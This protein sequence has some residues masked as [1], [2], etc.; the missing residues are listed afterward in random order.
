MLTRIAGIKDAVIATLALLRNDLSL[1]TNDWK[2]IEQAIPILKIFNDIT[3][4]IS[5]EKKLLLKC[6]LRT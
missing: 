6:A 2:I 3:V 5:A 1:S 4:E